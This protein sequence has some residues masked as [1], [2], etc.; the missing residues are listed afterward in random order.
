[1][2]KEFAVHL[3]RKPSLDYDPFFPL[4]ADDAVPVWKKM[5]NLVCCV[6]NIGDSSANSLEITRPAPKTKEQLA[7]EAA[8]F[9]FEPKK[10]RRYVCNAH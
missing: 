6:D 3:L 1:M 10:W 4:L 5:F 7:Q 8:D 9:L 2:I